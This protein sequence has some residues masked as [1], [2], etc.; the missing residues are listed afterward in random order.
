LSGNRDLD[1]FAFGMT[2]EVTVRLGSFNVVVL[3]MT[4]RVANGNGT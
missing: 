2:E 3:A 1:Y 4:T